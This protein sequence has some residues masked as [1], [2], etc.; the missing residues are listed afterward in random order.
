MDPE[1]QKQT[2]LTRN[3]LTKAVETSYREIAMD[4]GVP[5]GEEQR[6]VQALSKIRDHVVQAITDAVPGAVGKKSELSEVCRAVDAAVE[7][8]IAMVAESAK[9]EDSN[10]ALLRQRISDQHDKVKTQIENDFDLENG[11]KLLGPGVDYMVCLDEAL[12]QFTIYVTSHIDRLYESLGAYHCDKCTKI[13]FPPSANIDT[14]FGSA[15]E[16][17]ITDA[18]NR[19]I[20]GAKD[21]QYKK[22]RFG[23]SEFRKCFSHFLEK[24]NSNLK[25]HYRLKGANLQRLRS[26]VFS[27]MKELERLT[28]EEFLQAEIPDAF[29]K[30]Y[31]N[32]RA[33]YRK[34]VGDLMKKR[35]LRSICPEQPGDEDDLVD[36][37]EEIEE[38]AQVG[39]ETGSGDATDIQ[40]VPSSELQP[41]PVLEFEDHGGESLEKI[42]EL[43]LKNPDA[44]VRKMV[45]FVFE[46]AYALGFTKGMYF[47]DHCR[48]LHLNDRSKAFDVEKL[49]NTG[50]KIIR[51]LSKVIAPFVQAD[52]VTVNIKDVQKEA[53]IFLGKKITDYRTSLTECEGSA[54]R[55]QYLADLLER[56]SSFGSSSFSDDVSPAMA[57]VFEHFQVQDALSGEVDLTPCLEGRWRDYVAEKEKLSNESPEEN[58]SDDV[59]EKEGL[60]SGEPSETAVF[61]DPA[62]SSRPPSDPPPSERFESVR[63]GKLAE[64]E[65]GRIR[66]ILEWVASLRTV[67]KKTYI[68]HEMNALARILQERN[69]HPGSLIVYAVL[70]LEEIRNKISVSDDGSVST[71]MTSDDILQSFVDIFGQIG[72]ELPVHHETALLIQ[73]R[74]EEFDEA[75]SLLESE[76]DDL[77]SA[78]GKHQLIGDQ[79]AALIEESSVLVQER[80]RKEQERLILRSALN[81]LL[82]DDDFSGMEEKIREASEL[83]I[84]LGEIFAR[85][86]AIAAELSNL[87]SAAAQR[88]AIIEKMSGIKTKLS[89]LYERRSKFVDDVRSLLNQHL[90]QS[91]DQLHLQSSPQ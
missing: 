57:S 69:R 42:K 14:A 43:Y 31:G 47:C 39:T 74:L 76:F 68:R 62:F 65:E 30:L 78:L 75:I 85:S 83:K 23:F 59:E 19:M 80:V 34:R 12:L 35:D 21:Y 71:G 84:R 24:R 3:F 70:K 91:Q 26:F 45:F 60:Q 25:I 40:V 81:G 11:T 7:D 6:I 54:M 1:A 86:E 55:V 61:S 89:S 37:V 72:F 48:T 17:I 22:K 53:A 4:L 77:E 73:T 20:D 13:H 38:S 49:M 9:L 18:L 27:L 79:K 51:Q 46:P 82:A 63:A 56:V 10:I 33:Y 16:Q 32:T 90:E 29:S 58:S 28:E 15:L 64:I 87:D 52:P 8:G 50:R 36:V 88:R 66:D 44:F 5:E 41:P 67:Q 2:V